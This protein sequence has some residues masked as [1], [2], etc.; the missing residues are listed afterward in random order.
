MELYKLKNVDVDYGYDDNGEEFHVI[1]GCCIFARNK[2]WAEKHTSPNKNIFAQV[3]KE[4]EFACDLMIYYESGMDLEKLKVTLSSLK[5]SYLKCI[6]YLGK[7]VLI[8]KKTD[9]EAKRYLMNSGFSWRIE[10]VIDNKTKDECY[11]LAQKHST[12]MYYV[13]IDAGVEI[14]HNLFEKVMKKVYEECKPLILI[15]FAN[16]CMIY[17]KLHEKLKGNGKPAVYNVETGEI[18]EKATTFE[19]EIEKFAIENKEEHT[20]WQT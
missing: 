20:I 9:H 14:S 10:T 4:T 1:N 17:R 18:I 8:T 12:A 15:K 2:S 16:G 19:E 11:D 6:K 5:D 3:L 7:V 13:K